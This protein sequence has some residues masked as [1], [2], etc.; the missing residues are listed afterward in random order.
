MTAAKAAMKL[1]IENETLQKMSD[2][3]DNIGGSL[4]QYYTQKANADKTMVQELKLFLGELGRHLD[5]C[6][7]PC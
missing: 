2:N 6:S 4:T 5:K 3:G 7:Q 1:T